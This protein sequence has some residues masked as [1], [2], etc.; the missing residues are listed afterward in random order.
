MLNSRNGMICTAA[1]LHNKVAESR[2]NMSKVV[3]E[4]EGRKWR[5]QFDWEITVLDY[6]SDKRH[7]QNI[8]WFGR[9]ILCIER[10]SCS[11]P[12]L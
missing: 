4:G 1:A 8:T 2:Q 5:R 7:S 9:L 3:S 12:T 6:I 11:Y 10:A